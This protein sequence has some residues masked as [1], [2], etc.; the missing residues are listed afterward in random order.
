MSLD[1]KNDENEMYEVINHNAV[2]RYSYNCIIFIIF[3]ST[4]SEL[5][6][7]NRSSRQTDNIQ[8]SLRIFLHNVDD[9]NV[10]H[11]SSCCHDNNLWPSFK[12]LKLVNF[13]KTL[14]LKQIACCIWLG[15]HLSLHL[16][17]THSLDDTST[18][19][20]QLWAAVLIEVPKV[21]IEQNIRFE[22][23]QLH[24]PN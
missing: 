12:R 7:K 14:Y 9:N 13:C 18:C 24:L 2:P 3:S 5:V 4:R 22:L 11:S 19:I 1:D 15:M 21:L 16:S 8:Y 17:W 23:S 20:G 10:I 6:D